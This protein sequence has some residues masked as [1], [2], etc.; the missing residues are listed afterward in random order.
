MEKHICSVNKICIN[1]LRNWLLRDAFVAAA[2]GESEEKRR[3]S[4]ANANKNLHLYTHYI[5]ISS[6]HNQTNLHSLVQP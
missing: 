3:Q 4:I 6:I 2:A 1:L 5:Q